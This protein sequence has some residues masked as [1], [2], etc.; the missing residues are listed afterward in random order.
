M[1]CTSEMDSQKK[2]IFLETLTNQ[3]EPTSL[4]LM[5]FMDSF[6]LITWKWSTQ[7]I[8]HFYPSHI[9]TCRAWIREA[10]CLRFQ[11][12]QTKLR[13]NRVSVAFSLSL[14]YTNIQKII[15][16][17]TELKQVTWLDLSKDWCMLWRGVE[18]VL[19]GP[20]PD[21]CLHP[22]VQTSSYTG[23]CPR[24]PRGRKQTLKS[25]VSVWWDCGFPLLYS[26]SLR[27]YSMYMLL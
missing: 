1:P 12:W 2:R 21:R 19:T 25:P 10:S 11:L 22:Q 6:S 23:A 17:Y 7:D 15:C 20:F 14:S 3:V 26:T 4:S 9:F 13:T 16:A 24:G 27:S 5:L 18:P 8:T